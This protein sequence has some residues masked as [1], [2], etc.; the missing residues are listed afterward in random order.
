MTTGEHTG[1]LDG[2]ML[3]RETRGLR[4]VS[5]SQAGYTDGEDEWVLAQ[6]VRQPIERFYALGPKVLHHGSDARMHTARQL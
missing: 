4:G 6:P 5:L 2:R 3:R 1:R